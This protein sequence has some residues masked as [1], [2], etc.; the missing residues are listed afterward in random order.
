MS[1]FHWHRCFRALT[2]ETVAQAVRRIRLE[3]AAMALI[4]SADDIARIAAQVGYPNA[5]SFSRAF[6]DQFGLTPT[7]F[8]RRGL[9]PARYQPGPIKEFPM[10][11]IEIT[12]RPALRLAALDHRGDYNRI[13]QTFERLTAHLAANG[14]LPQARGMVG[15]YYNNPAETPVA[16]LRSHAAIIVDEDL[17]IAAPLTEVRLPAGRAAV[18]HHHGS[19]A[20]LAAAYDQLYCDWLPKSGEEPGDAPAYEVYLNSPATTAP[21]ALRTDICLLLRD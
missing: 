1:R 9:P 6:G 21:E 16:D 11:P 13:G 5:A 15:V 18:L 8:R 20:T 17:A 12:Q 4:H 3:R 7:A 14:L 2:G 19:Y 10:H